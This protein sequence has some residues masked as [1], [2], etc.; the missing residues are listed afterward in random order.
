MLSSS[1]RSVRALGAGVLAVAVAAALAACGG[2][3]ESGDGA[4]EGIK[5]WIQEDLPDRVAATQ[6]IVDSFTAAS[7]VEVELVPVA[8]DQFNQVLTSAAAAGDLP[9]VIGGISLPQVRTLSSNELLDTGAVGDVMDG[10][11]ESTFSERA[12][13]LTRDGDTQLAVPSE[14][15]TQLLY[16]R[17]DLFEAAGLEPP[18]SYDAI[19]AAA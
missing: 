7:G 2:D 18:T 17:T 3:E 19:L 16:Y 6:K 5:V 15:W 14:S 12:V 10:L 13:E 1:R 4:A 8:E 11:D 9:D